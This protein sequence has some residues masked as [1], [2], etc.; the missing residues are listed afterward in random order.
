MATITKSR[1]LRV[2]E[3]HHV[4]IFYPEGRRVSKPDISEAR[5]A[6]SRPKPSRLTPTTMHVHRF[7]YNPAGFDDYW[8]WRR[9]LA[10]A[11]WRASASRVVDSGAPSTAS[12]GIAQQRAAAKF[13]GQDL[14]L[15][16]GLTGLRQSYKMVA[17]KFG[18]LARFLENVRRYGA[19][20]AVRRSGTGW[21]TDG[22]S[23][24][25]RAAD[26]YL[27]TS[28]GW[29][30]AVSDA[31]G[32]S[33]AIERG[34]SGAGT[35]VSGRATE[36]TSKHPLGARGFAKVT[37]SGTI[38]HP[39]MRALNQLGLNNPALIAWQNVPLSFVADWFVGLSDALAYMTWG[40]GL[41]NKAMCYTSCRVH[42]YERR[43]PSGEWVS[44]YEHEDIRRTV[45]SPDFIWDGLMAD[46]KISLNL[47]VIATSAALIAQRLTSR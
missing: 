37:L 2:H 36:Y 14:D 29:L 15:G 31:Y 43:R 17:G 27:E 16:E 28:F 11:S 39:G 38:V 22:V 25:K 12:A 7:R 34:L 24:T 3:W 20:E 40:A 41:S 33:S 19:R 30:Q 44:W 45:T 21:S 47:S 18:M 9:G 26:S 46:R 32:A 10:P 35:F 6:W 13:R 23:N 8:G 42:S 5:A 1:T 4:D